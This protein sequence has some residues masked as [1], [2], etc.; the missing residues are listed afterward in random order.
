VTTLYA[1][2]I[3]DCRCRACQDNHGPIPKQPLEQI[4]D[5]R[6]GG[7]APEVV[8]LV[9]HILDQPVTVWEPF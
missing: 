4:R 2:W 7:N 3:Y 5:W 9:G 1:G 6:I 8:E